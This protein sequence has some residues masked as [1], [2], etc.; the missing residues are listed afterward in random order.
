MRFG[1]GGASLQAGCYITMSGDTI[2]ASTTARFYAVGGTTS[3]NGTET[4]RAITPS[5]GSTYSRM[6]IVLTAN[7]LDVD[8]DWTFRIG[9]AS[10]II[11][12]TLPFGVT[13]LFTDN[14]NE[15]TAV[16]T[17]P[18]AYFIEFGSGV[19]SVLLRG[20]SI[21]YRGITT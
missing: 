3:D 20:L 6:Q 7:T 4:N 12:L 17:D 2:L 21:A 19:G 1:G 14:V 15:A 9:L 11:T 18:I 8:A 5:F 10:S 16:Y 13:G